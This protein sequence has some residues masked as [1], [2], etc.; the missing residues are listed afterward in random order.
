M[1]SDSS[2]ILVYVERLKSRVFTREVS[3][4]IA[5]TQFFEG[6]RGYYSIC[7][8]NAVSVPRLFGSD[9]I[10]P[11]GDTLCRSGLCHHYSQFSITTFVVFLLM[12]SL[13]L[14]VFYPSINTVS[15]TFVIVIKVQTM[16]WK[17]D[18]CPKNSNED[19]WQLP[20]IGSTKK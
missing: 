15:S 19:L 20:E 6:E 5:I 14:F 7:N 13:P 17:V 10:W 4:S 8:G 16:L 3:A 11:E 12:Y 9:F 1:K 2:G 18:I